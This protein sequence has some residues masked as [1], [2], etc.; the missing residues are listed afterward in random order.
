M[1][2]SPLRVLPLSRPGSVRFWRLLKILL[3]LLCTMAAGAALHAQGGLIGHWTFDNTLDDSAGTAHGTFSD[4]TPVYTAGKFGN[5]VSLDGINDH[6]VLGTS[7]HLNFGS[8]IDFSVAL[9]VKTKG[10]NTDASIISNKDWYSGSYTGWVVAGGHGT[11]TWQW[12]FCGATGSRADYD[13]GAPTLDDGRWHHLCVT[14]DRDGDASFYV[15][16]VPYTERDISVST[17]TIDA[18]L[19]TVVGTDGY[20]GQQ[21]PYWFAGQIDELRIYDKILSQEEIE[22]LQGPEGEEVRGS[23]VQFVGP[24]TAVVRWETDSMCNSIVEYGLTE[25][26]GSRIEISGP[27]TSHEITIPDLEYRTEYFFRVGNND[28]QGD[29]FS[30]VRTFDNA[31]FFAPMDCSDLETPFTDDPGLTALYGEAADRIITETSI[32]RGYCLVYGCNA[33]ELAFELAKRSDL[34]LFGVDTDPSQVALARRRL[35]EAGVYGHRIKIFEQPLL[36]ALPFSRNFFNL[37]VSDRMISDGVCVGSAAE[38]Y[39]VLRPSGGRAFLG[40]PDGCPNPLS[41]SDLENWLQAG[42]VPYTIDASDGI[43]ADVVRPTLPGAG[44]WPRQYGWPDNAANSNDDL[45]GATRTDQMTVQW[46]GRPG[47]DFGADRQPRMPPPV[48][49]N[50]RLFHQGLNRLVAMDAYN[51]SIFWSLEIPE[52]LR[53]NTPRDGGSITADDS[54]VFIALHNLCWRLGGD[55]GLLVRR[56]RIPL[57]GH[58]WGYVAVSDDKLFGSA[59]YEGAHYTNIWGNSSWYDAT[60]GAQTDKVCSRYLFAMDKVEEDWLWWYGNGVIINSTITMGGGRIYFVECRNQTI[61]DLPYGRIG[62][63]LLWSDQFLVALDEDSGV[64]LWETPIDTADGIVVFFG[65]YGDGKVFIASS[66]KKYHLYAYDAANG[67]F[68]WSRNHNW[69]KNNHGGHMQHPVIAGG[70]IYLE[71]R[72]Y[73]LA[74]GNQVT[75]NM[76]SHGGCATYAGSAGAFVY[77]GST[78]RMSMWDINSGDVTS[79]DGIRPACWLSTITG[80]GMVLCPEGGGGCSCNG[81]INTSVGFI[82]DD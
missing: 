59:Q 77:R 10:W 11:G 58:E 33:G 65:L 6:I 71:P 5:A 80:G 35:M 55:S 70:A 12:N 29:I 56:F 14:H 79:W 52:S 21:W 19:P 46:L 50:G 24:Y 31:I 54:S 37:I 81:W 51:G 45:E 38:L 47:S 18:G 4:G 7:S 17:G 13:P 28:G 2:H 73:D 8:S 40:Q 30:E 36:E 23:R 61:R 53:V 39:R 75:S 22:A 41:R 25:A 69:P 44:E 72:G 3:L 60:S 49:K 34:V 42:S 16:G 64:K 57:A 1:S 48:M 68:I 43:W 66:E 26:L 67:S 82:R 20:Q 76:G 74:T 62:D 27:A 63:A 15:D 78:G 9:W 32:T